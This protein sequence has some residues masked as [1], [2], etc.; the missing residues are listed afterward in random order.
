MSAE[1]AAVCSTKNVELIKSLGADSVIDY[2]QTDFTTDTA[3]YDMI[4]DVVGNQSFSGCQSV[5]LTARIIRLLI[6]IQHFSDYPAVCENFG[7]TRPVR[8]M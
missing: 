3:K 1:V 5:E 8:V 4:F 2:T 6:N 7:M